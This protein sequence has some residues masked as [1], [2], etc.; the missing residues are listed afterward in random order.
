MKFGYEEKICRR[1]I[2]FLIVGNDLYGDNV[3]NGDDIQNKG[4]E[5]V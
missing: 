1:N 4:S 5:D 3:G 2:V